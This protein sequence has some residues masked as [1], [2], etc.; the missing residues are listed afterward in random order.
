MIKSISK[1]I[2]KLFF[3]KWIIGIYRGDIKTVISTKTFDPD[4]KWLFKQKFDKFYGDPFPLGC[5]NGDIK[6]IVEDYSYDDDYG[7]L[8]LMTFDKYLRLVNNKLLLD[9]NS[10]LSFPFV[11]TENNRTYIFP[12]ARRSGKLSCYEFNAENETV[13]FLQDILELPLLDSTVL[14]HDNLFWI[15]GTICDKGVA[16][17]RLKIFYSDNLLGPYTPHPGNPLREGMDGIRSAGGFL[18]IDGVIYRPTQNCREEYGKSISIYKITDLTKTSFREEPHMNIRINKHNR[19]N[20]G[21]HKIHT[22]NVLDDII[23]VDGMN[24]T[25]SPL[26]KLKN[27]KK[28][29]SN[30]ID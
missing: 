24:W 30:G 25:F 9:T 1:L 4:I 22:I 23:L 16:D 15:F 14:K 21:M 18:N 8:S 7:K 29:F 19:H 3:K 28:V 10:H 13:T 27:L 6:I 5:E 20:S 2:D 12:E 26:K 11:I 17:Y